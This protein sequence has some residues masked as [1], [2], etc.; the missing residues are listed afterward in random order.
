M[1]RVVLLDLLVERAEFGHGGNLE[2][3]SPFLS[4][5]DSIECLLLTPQMEAKNSRAQGCIQL[6]EKDIPRWDNDFPFWQEYT[7]NFDKGTIHFRRIKMPTQ[8]SFLDLKP[9]AIICSGSRKNVSMWEPWME[10][11]AELLR[12]GIQQDIPTLGICFGHQLLATALGGKVTRAEKYTD[13]VSDLVHHES[14]EVVSVCGIGLFTHQDHVTSLPSGVTHLASAKHCGYAA[15]RVDG[16]KAWGVQFHPEAARARIER[17]FKLGHINEEELAAFKR[18][19]EG[20]ALL[21]AFSE[22][23]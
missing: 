14:D 16:K 18:D 10:A 3:L 5:S 15:F 19:H 20:A 17:S 6:Q 21:L 8:S 22:Q 1:T 11:C 7:E 9:D 4:K 12:W 2:V 13:V 23:V